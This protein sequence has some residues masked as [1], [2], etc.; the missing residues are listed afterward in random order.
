MKNNTWKLIQKIVFQ[1]TLILLLLLAITGCDPD[2]PKKEDA[3]EAI[4]QVKLTFSPTDGSAPV[5]VTANDPDG[6]GVLDFL[7]DKDVVLNADTEYL[8]TLEMFNGL[9]DPNSDGYD[10]GKEVEEEGDEHILLFGWTNGIFA[11][12]QGNG[13]VD[14]RNDPVNYLDSDKNNLP[15]GLETKW[16]TASAGAV[17][18]GG[19]R[20]ILKHQPGIKT[21]SSGAGDGE[22]DLDI[23][24]S[25]IVD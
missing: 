7:A 5:E 18:T 4:T 3:P 11:S 1:N 2:D 16:K 22:T 12:P 17:N 20:I 25:L 21:T 24:F 15:L 14:S 23:S 9:A 8:L 13:N 19:F 10:I 6:E